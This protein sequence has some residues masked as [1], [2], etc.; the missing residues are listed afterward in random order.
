MLSIEIDIFMGA[1]TAPMVF[2]VKD[3]P[4]ILST[5]FL[6]LIIVVYFWFIFLCLRAMR[7]YFF[8]MINKKITGFEKDLYM[9]YNKRFIMVFDCYD[10]NSKF[11]PILTIFTVIKDM[12]FPLVLIYGVSNPVYQVVPMVLV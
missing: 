4:N 6:V 10:Q 9:K 7:C 11:G 8:P 5:I 1:W 12:L 2:H 3:I